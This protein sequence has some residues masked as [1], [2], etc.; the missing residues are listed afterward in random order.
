MHDLSLITLELVETS[1]YEI[2]DRQLRE[3]TEKVGVPR[4]ILSDQGSDIVKGARLF[5]DSHANTLVC[6][7]MAHATAVALKKEL[8]SDERWNTFVSQCGATQPKVKQTEL[9]YLA[10]AKLKVKGRYMNLGALIGWG[11]SMLNV[12]D[13]PK[14]DRPDDVDLERLDEKFG[15]V[16]DYRQAI[17]EWSRLHEIKNVVL[18]FSRVEGY[19]A[20]AADQL[21]SLLAPLAIHDSGRRVARN[22][23]GVVRA[24]SAALRDEES[25]PASSEIL[26]SLIGK[27]KRLSGQHT[28]GGFTKNVLAMAAS[29]V[30]LT[31][32]TILTALETCGEKHLRQ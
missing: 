24:Q 11:G 27:G 14:A 22:L 25:L 26:E 15:W 23:V 13:T 19:H 9:G 2:V 28:R 5:Q 18:N 10:P 8:T 32:E 30:E 31:D 17:A 16:S 7:D 6:K 12:L 4:S 29:L 21:Q 20:T 1:N 3:A